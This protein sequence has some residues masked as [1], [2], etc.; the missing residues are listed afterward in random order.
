MTNNDESVGSSIANGTQDL[1]ALVGVFG[2]DSVDRNALATQQGTISVAISSLSMLGLLGLVK[3]TLKIT[4]G[5]DRCRAAGFNLD[6]IRGL[7]GYGRGEPASRG[8][9]HL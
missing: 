7:F 5:L 9:Y 2:T 6:S 1:A 4:L 3:S 8:T